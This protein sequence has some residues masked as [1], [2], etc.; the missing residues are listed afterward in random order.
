MV[1]DD[2][3]L[4]TTGPTGCP[5]YWAQAI[6]TVLFSAVHANHIG[7][8]PLA[9][10]GRP[11]LRFVLPGGCRAARSCPTRLGRNRVDSPLD[12]ALEASWPDAGRPREGGISRSYALL[13]DTCDCYTPADGNVTRGH[14]LPKRIRMPLLRTI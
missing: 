3:R 10:Q 7:G 5:S 11:A 12:Q 1:A 13:E 6:P 8:R 14:A 9:Q 4:A 2:H